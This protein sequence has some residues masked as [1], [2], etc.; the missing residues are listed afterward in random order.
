MNGF[1]Y[2]L[3]FELTGI[4]S[5][6]VAFI[7]DECDNFNVDIGDVIEGVKKSI[8]GTEVVIDADII[9]EEIYM[10]ALRNLNV[11]LGYI[12]DVNSEH[13]ISLSINCLASRL[14]IG[15]TEIHNIKELETYIENNPEIIEEQ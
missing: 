9:I 7:K 12:D 13:N 8:D 4:G 5:G 10:L 3:I 1:L 14:Y 6:D 15:D 11:N 2:N